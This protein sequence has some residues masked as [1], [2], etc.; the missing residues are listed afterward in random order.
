MKKQAVVVKAGGTET[1]HVMGCQLSFLCRSQQTDHAWSLMETVLPKDM[2]PPPHDHPWDECYYVVEGQVRFSLEGREQL[3]GAGD[4]VYAPR[5]TLHG[6]R[7][8]S[9]KPA[10]MLVFD[11]PAHTEGFFRDVEREVKEMPR[12]LPKVPEI[13]LRHQIRFVGP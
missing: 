10:R 8:D 5:G 13:G 12:D 6:F 4:F 7:G 2:G 9:E 11:A 3:I 1:M